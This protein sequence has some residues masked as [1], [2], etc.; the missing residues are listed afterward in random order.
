M[1]AT[2]QSIM[3]YLLRQGWKQQTSR[4]GAL[5]RFVGVEGDGSPPV[6]IFFSTESGGA[7]ADQAELAAAL[8][9]IRQVYGLSE[10]ALHAMLAALSYDKIL[11]TVPDD[12]LRHE[13]IELR[14]ARSYLNGMKGI[15]A[16]SATTVITGERS[17]RRTVKEAKEFADECRFA[18]TFKGSFGLAIESPV[19]LNNQTLMP[20]VEPELPLGRKTLRRITAGLESLKKAYAQ[21]DL[22]PILSAPEGLNANMC[23]ELVGI[24]EGTGI[25][26]IELSFVL[27]PEW[28]PETPLPLPFKI[29]SRYRDILKEA[30]ARLVKDDTESDV[31]IFGRIVNLHAAGDP[32]DLMDDDA[33]RIIQVNW[34]S[35]DL[36]MV[37]VSVSLDP[38]RYLVAV[39]AHRQGRPI[40][41]QG[42]LRRKGRLWSLQDPGDLT[43]V[44][45]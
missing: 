8:E 14:A 18:H 27:S 13:S 9:T 24:I 30:S 11:A 44:S 42:K 6:N 10:S 43:V 32:S 31:A 15:I 38:A 45:I 4:D 35:P 5:T 29:E 41:M 2:K 16:A 1:D 19:G 33:D 22:G 26:R 21:D 36:G 37:K 20:F 28:E 40:T 7:D 34:D 3:R 17:F 23:N 12:Y 39:E 25:P